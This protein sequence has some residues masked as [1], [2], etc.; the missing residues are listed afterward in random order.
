M[1]E[2]IQF[3]L[4]TSNAA[5]KS[6]LAEAKQSVTS[7]KSQVTGIL[8][9]MFAGMGIQQ[10]ISDFAHVQDLADGLGSTAE[11]VQRVRG[12]GELAGTSLDSIAKSM[13]KLRNDADALGKLGIDA[14]AFSDAGMDEQVLMVSQALDK[15]VDPQ[16]RI[17]T[18]LEVFGMKGRE[19]LPMFTQGYAALKE[20]MDGVA[21]AS[22]E[23][24]KRFAAM[25]DEIASLTNTF[26]V[27]AAQGINVVV[28]GIR[29]MS[30]AAGYAYAYIVNLPKGF[31]AA[32]AAADAYRE[33]YLQLE[34]EK[35]VKQEKA[36]QE[37]K[38]L[39]AAGDGES[40]GGGGK[41]LRE[42]IADLEAA[43]LEKQLPIYQQL[44][45]IGAERVDIERQIAAASDPEKKKVLEE[46][47][48]ANTKQRLA[49]ED[50]AR[51][52]GEEFEKKISAEKADSEKEA[53]QYR[54]KG[55]VDTLA[56]AKKAAHD[57]AEAERA[58]MDRMFQ[59]RQADLGFA[60]GVSGF[61][62]SGQR[63]AGVNYSVINA[64]AE[65]GIKLQ[66]EMRNYLKS[67]DE[68]KWSV[69]IPEAL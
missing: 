2:A 40:G 50:Q 63:L 5:F 69:E 61:D 9:G 35:E 68:K 48:L 39:A 18:A 6:G 53:A 21:V 29:N 34:F 17:N 56:A 14:K 12:A 66:E 16:Q 32:A 41:S 58:I 51:K 52:D 24:V 8:S 30:T 7:F 22:D 44:A 19:I 11:Q 57:R 27:W 36:A 62:G 31:E 43:A 1:R 23:D 54:I 10:L 55:F 67:I 15:I 13:A 49:L 46:E 33:S 60:S 3:T 65:K 59:S 26:K 38:N 47:L 42:K 64:E 4:G 28:D 37:K 25:D 20:S 45:D